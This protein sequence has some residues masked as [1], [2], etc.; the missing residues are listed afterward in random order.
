MWTDD[1]RF[2]AW[3]IFGSFAVFW[4]VNFLVVILK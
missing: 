4:I 3:L 2:I 1:I